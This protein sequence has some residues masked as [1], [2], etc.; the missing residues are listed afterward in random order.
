MGLTKVFSRPKLNLASTTTPLYLG[1]ET[2]P[3][4]HFLVS[5]QRV[6]LGTRVIEINGTKRLSRKKK[7]QS[8][9]AHVVLV[10]QLEIQ[11]WSHRDKVTLQG[12]SDMT[13]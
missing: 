1:R 5:R 12:P 2:P 3:S 8:H 13:G 11:S 6:L 7:N 9:R 10:W 4:M